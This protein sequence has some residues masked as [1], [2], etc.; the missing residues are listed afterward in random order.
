MKKVILGMVIFFAFVFSGQPVSAQETEFSVVVDY[1]MTAGQ[2]VGAAH[3]KWVHPGIKS[4]IKEV[5][6]KGEG[7]VEHELVLV[8]LGKKASTEEVMGE[9]ARRGLKPAKVDDLLALSAA[10]PD[11]PSLIVALGSIWEFFENTAFSYITGSGEKRV[12]SL[13]SPWGDFEWDE[14]WYFLAVPA[15]K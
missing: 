2:M 10:N 13:I 15:K 9:F 1:S 14:D 4:T 12:L 7:K 8:H 5:Q 11:L 6:L 3:F